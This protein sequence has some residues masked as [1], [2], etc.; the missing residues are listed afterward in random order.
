MRATVFLPETAPK[1]KVERLRGYGTD[2]RLGGSKDAAAPAACEEYAARRRAPASHAYDH[3]LI[4]A[5]AGTLSLG[6]RRASAAAVH[7]A[8]VVLCGAHTDPADLAS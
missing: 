7:A 1:V 2:V 8:G 5:G 3:R 6:A 4:A